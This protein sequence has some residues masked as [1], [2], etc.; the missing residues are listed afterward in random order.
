MDRFDDLSTRDDLRLAD[1]RAHL[2]AAAGPRR[3][4]GRYYVAATAGTAGEPGI[5]VGDFKEWAGV[6]ASYG[7]AYAWAGASVQL[8]RRT[9]MAMV[10]STVPS[11]QSAL[12]GASVDSRFI[13]T[14]RVDSREP[15]KDIVRRLNHF[16]PD[17][18]VGYA[19]MLGL[20]AG[21]QRAGRLHVQPGAVLSASE[22]LTV[23]ARRDVEQAWNRRPS[24]VYAA[25]ETAG[26]AAEC[27]QH[28]GM[29]LFKDLVI[30]EVVDDEG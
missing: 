26:I 15:L 12:V 17:V 13:P 29:H 8:T 9:R 30:T 22:V 10:S 6:L 20:L 4:R 3:L 1:A 23:E 27:A 18:L 28:A 19:S 11:H 24:D 14:L 2:A 5:F 21:E 16:R 25:T 7:R